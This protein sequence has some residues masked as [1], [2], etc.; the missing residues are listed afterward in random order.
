MNIVLFTIYLIFFKY[1]IGIEEL[2]KLSN[3]TKFKKNT[4]LRQT[5]QMYFLA[6]AICY[7]KMFKKDTNFIN[8]ILDLHNNVIDFLVDNKMVRKK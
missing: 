3:K 6:C 7:K 2:N 1:G 5:M 8:H 4:V